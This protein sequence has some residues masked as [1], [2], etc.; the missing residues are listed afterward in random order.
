MYI[1][2]FFALQ[3]LHSINDEIRVTVTDTFIVSHAYDRGY[4]RKDYGF[5]ND[6][7]IRIQEYKNAKL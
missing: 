3:W 4:G 2:F 6:D 1:I 5:R 7:D